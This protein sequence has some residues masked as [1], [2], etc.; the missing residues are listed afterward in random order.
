MVK[1]N[2]TGKNGQQSAAIQLVSHHYDANIASAHTSQFGD[3]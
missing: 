1:I 2:E 3:N